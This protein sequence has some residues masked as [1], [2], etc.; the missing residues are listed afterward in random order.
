MIYRIKVVINEIIISFKVGENP[1]SLQ[2]PIESR[3]QTVVG[4]KLI[5]K[6]TKTNKETTLFH[7]VGLKFIIQLRNQII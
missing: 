3:I 2:P 6:T 5:N 7:S 4:V 1:I